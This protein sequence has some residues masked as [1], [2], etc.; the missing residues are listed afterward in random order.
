MDARATRRLMAGFFLSGVLSAFL[1]TI[2]PVWGH[3][4]KSA[5]L[6]AGLYFLF[7][8]LGVAGATDACRRL[9]RRKPL[10]FILMHS[11]ILACAG[12]LV[13]GIFAP[14][15]HPGWRM[16]G[17]FLLGA[18]TGS[19][20]TALF[21]AAQ[22]IY[23]FDSWAALNLGSICFGL[24]SL[25][26][27]LVVAGAYYAYSVPVILLLIAPLP[28]LLAYLYNRTAWP[29]VERLPEPTLR[30]A[31]RDF[32]SFGAVLLALILFFQFGNEWSASGWLAVFLIQRIGMSPSSALLLLAFY[33]FSLLAG[34]AV[35]TFLLPRVAHGKL[36]F[37][38]ALASVFG[39][40]VLLST[41]TP[42][43][44]LCG[45]AVL[46]CGFAPVYPLVA[47]KI[48]DRYRYFRPG[49]FNGIFSFALVGGMLAPWSVGV[50]AHYWDV[51]AVMLL[52]LAG[53]CMVVLLLLLLWL[54]AKIRG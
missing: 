49:F 48:G 2:L 12:L 41:T 9:L 4:L 3:H 13:L 15:A 30:E 14:P 26:M 6:V 39:C 17:L 8:S 53:T 21:H 32:R 10:G 54:E 29:A 25:S 52:P 34:R 16:A 43:G 1:G 42:L 31:L 20:S 47:E 37:G 18:A 19:L 50:F 46:G 22:P 11:C 5:F 44:A 35:A 7:F 36:L 23:R 45:L 27:A 40:M 24:G 51:A 33:W 28:A 38:G